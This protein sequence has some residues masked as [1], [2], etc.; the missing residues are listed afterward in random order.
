MVCPKT[1][2]FFLLLF[3]F[4]VHAKAKI[5]DYSNFEKQLQELNNKKSYSE[6]I[7]LVLS[8]WDRFPEKRFQLTKELS[9]LYRQTGDLQKCMETWEYGN[10]QGFFYCLHPEIPM[11]KTFSDNERFKKISEV[12]LELRKQA[13]QNSKMTYQLVLPEHMQAG[14]YYPLVMILHGGSSNIEQEMKH[15]HSPFLKDSCL[16]AFIQSYRR[17]DSDTYGWMGND[18]RAMA[19]LADIFQKIS[20]EYSVDKSK[21]VM[22]G[23]SAGALVAIETAFAQKF[24]VSG[25]LG[26]CPDIKPE[27]FDSQMVATAGKTG[28]SGIMICG[29][30]DPRLENQKRTSEKFAQWGFP[31]RSIVID[32]LG[33]WYPDN[34]PEVIDSSLSH[35]YGKLTDVQK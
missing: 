30:K 33:H 11:Y 4:T 32:G 19:D 18:P 27:K 24:S 10:S 1:E 16:T 31:H 14:K 13:N 3:L 8:V 29:E 7:Q 22:A 28:L 17:F 2:I 12:D 6:A 26:I 25:F 5:S 21:V 20:R 34:F 15:W 35:I 9:Y 23:I